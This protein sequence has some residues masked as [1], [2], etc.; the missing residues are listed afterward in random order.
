MK[1]GLQIIAMTSP[2]RIPDEALKIIKL[3]QNGDADIVHI[4]KPDWDI[5]ETSELISSIPNQY[6]GRIKIHDYFSLCRKFHLLGPHLNSRNPKAD[7]PCTHISYSA[8]SIEQLSLLSHYDYVTLSP[9]FDSISK[10]GYLSSFNLEDIRPHIEGKR[11]IALGGVTP[12]KFPKL[13]ASG[14]YGAA[15]LGYFWH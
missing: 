6:H 2:H 13:A 3:L 7:I 5:M 15:M 11:V 14:F 10:P 1:H 12:D 8:H 4:R 9:V